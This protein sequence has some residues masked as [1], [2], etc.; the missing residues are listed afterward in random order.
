MRP[1]LS[2]P[3]FITAIA[4]TLAAPRAFAGEPSPYMSH[5]V[6]VDAAHWFQHVTFKDVGLAAGPADRDGW[7]RNVTRVLARTLDAGL[8]ARARVEPSVAD[9]E[10]HRACHGQHVYVDVWRSAGP[11]RVGFS[12]WRGCGDDDRFAWQEV[13]ASDGWAASAPVVAKAIAHALRV[14]DAVTC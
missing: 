13:P 8:H 9:P 7:M 5:T 14:C 4:L 1:S 12:L 6:E 11:D 3:A 10:W 2:A